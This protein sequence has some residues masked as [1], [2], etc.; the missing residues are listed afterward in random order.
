MR[1]ILEELYGLFPTT[2]KCSALE[3]KR[4]D[5]EYLALSEK[6]QAVLGVGSMDRFLELSE[7]RLGYRGEAR[8]ASGVCVGARLMAEIFTWPTE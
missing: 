8:F 4:I 5:E 7:Q 1:S 6:I 3:Q 2:S